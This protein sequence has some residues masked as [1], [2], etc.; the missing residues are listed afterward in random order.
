MTG[1]IPQPQQ[2]HRNDKGL[3]KDQCRQRYDQR[4]QRLLK[5]QLS[6]NG[7]NSLDL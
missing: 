6:R 4:Q 3:H 7:I 1:I 5:D 2:Q